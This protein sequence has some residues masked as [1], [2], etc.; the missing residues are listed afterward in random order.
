MADRPSEF[1]LIAQL[2]APLAEA[3]GAFA[4]TDD[5]ALLPARA[6]HDLVATTDALVEGVHFLADDP[7]VSIAKKALRVNLSDLAAKGAEPAG[8][9]LAL[10]LPTQIDM[11][12]LEGFA[13]GLGEDQKTFAMPLLG[14][15]TTA[16]PGP[17]TLAITAMGY[18]PAGA[19]ICRAGAKPGDGVYVSG[20][21]GDA[22]GGLALLTGEGGDIRGCQAGALIERY[23]LPSPR[24]ALGQALR[25]VA[26]AA[27]DVSD[28]LIADLS[29]IAEISRVR[30]VVEAG[31]IPRSPALRALWGDTPDAIVRAATA[32]DDYEIAFSAPSEA[33]V[34]EA[35][36]R[37]GVAVTRIGGV[38]EGS[39]VV[40]LDSGGHEIAVSCAGFTHF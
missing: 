29:H 27:L 40:L 8:Y 12:W 39:G 11:A 31:R 6:G 38:V 36:E 21:I 14:G 5:V 13:R 23:R 25:G 2:F 24:L 22:G 35:A 10:S 7:S 17:L 32:G 16:T 28:G 19:L 3:P 9:L 15:D 26:S 30:I 20:T 33:M 4:L 37:A 1:A 18:V 34:M